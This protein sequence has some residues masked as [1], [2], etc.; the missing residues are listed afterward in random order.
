[1]LLALLVLPFWI[2]YLMRMLA[3]VNL[4]QTDGYV[5]RVLGWMQIGS[6]SRNWLD[7]DWPTVVMGLIYGY[8][9][10]FILP[11]YA[12]LERL[13]DRLIEAARDL[14]ASSFWTFVRVTL[15]LSVPGLMAA[16]VIIVLP[17]CGDYYTNTYLTGGSPRT[18]MVGNQIEFFLRGSS[19]PQTGAS[20]VIVLMAFL[21]VLMAYYLVT[22][23]RSQQRVG[24]LMK[25]R[26]FGPLAIVTWLYVL[27]S[28]VP[29]LIAVRI[30]FNSGKSRSAFQPCRCAGTGTT[31]RRSGGATNCRPPCA[32]R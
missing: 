9:P 13:D 15:P 18:E 21:M 31:R 2:S 26:R 8:I 1:M 23:A 22:I 7:G 19:Q 20:L 14:G 10:F 6:G 3:W 12:A 16:S 24:A 11:L 5:N 4:L 29:V 25:R 32:T 28:L 27:W 30:S 17:M